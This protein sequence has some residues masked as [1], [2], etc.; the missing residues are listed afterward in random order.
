[1][2]ISNQYLFYGYLGSIHPQLVIELRLFQMFVSEQNKVDL[3]FELL[4]L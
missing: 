3:V 1:M 2:L 4:K